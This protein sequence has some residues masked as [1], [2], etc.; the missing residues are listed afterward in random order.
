MF[1]PS[2][3]F[4]TRQ[5][6]FFCSSA[7]HEFAP[8]S[9]NTFMLSSRHAACVTLLKHPVW[10]YNNA[11]FPCVAKPPY[12]PMNLDC[13]STVDLVTVPGCYLGNNHAQPCI[14]VLQIVQHRTRCEILSEIVFLCIVNVYIHYIGR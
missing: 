7:L 11:S 12:V 2:S 6:G 3:G 4:C 5:S 10:L 8:S 1:S 13:A 14:F 9:I